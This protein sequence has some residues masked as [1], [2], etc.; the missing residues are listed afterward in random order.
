[1]DRPA[2]G[3]EER[4]CAFC[5]SGTINYVPRRQEVMPGTAVPG[6]RS[7]SGVRCFSLGPSGRT[8]AQAASRYRSAL[9]DTLRSASGHGGSACGCQLERQAPQLRRPHQH[10]QVRQ[11]A[12]QRRLGGKGIAVIRRIHGQRRP[13]GPNKLRLEQ[14][15]ILVFQRHGQSV[16]RDV[17]V[18]VRRPR[19]AQLFV[20]ANVPAHR[21]AAV[22]ITDTAPL[23]CRG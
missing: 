3:R 16:R 20:D 8:G 22:G 14:A 9:T 10:R 7:G 1:M 2:G 11:P 4:T 23:L 17:G 13:V 19:P 15:L 18:D 12:F 5:L 6:C 21:E